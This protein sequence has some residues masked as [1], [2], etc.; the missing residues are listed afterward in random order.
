[1]AKSLARKMKKTKRKRPMQQLARLTINK[2]RVKS[3]RVQAAVAIHLV[4]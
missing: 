4:K 3:Q 1:M 2:R